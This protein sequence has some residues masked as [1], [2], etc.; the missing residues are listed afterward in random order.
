MQERS[1]PTSSPVSLPRPLAASPPSVPK[2]SSTQ[3][4]RPPSDPSARSVLKEGGGVS[5]EPARGDREGD[6][7]NL[8]TEFFRQ[9]QTRLVRISQDENVSTSFRSWPIEVES[10]PGS[11]V[12]DFS[13]DLLVDEKTRSVVFHSVDEGGKGLPKGRRS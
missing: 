1:P 2:P 8:P 10:V 12:V 5:S 4:G 7:T 9:L 11:R 6:R 13:G 3:R